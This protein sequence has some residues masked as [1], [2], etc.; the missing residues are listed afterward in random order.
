MNGAALVA[1]CAALAILVPLDGARGGAIGTLVGEVTLA[2]V[3][4]IRLARCGLALDLAIVAR[5]ALAGAVALVPAF[6]L[7]AA[8]AAVVAAVLFLVVLLVLRAV[9]EELLIEARR[10]ARRARG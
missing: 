6:F 7:P 10:I 1:V 8:P 9:P 5:V 3:G 4:A 2:T